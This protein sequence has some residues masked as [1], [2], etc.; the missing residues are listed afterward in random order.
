MQQKLLMKCTKNILLYIFDVIRVLSDNVYST[1]IFLPGTIY[2]QVLIHFQVFKPIKV[3]ANA[4]TVVGI[5]Y[6]CPW[7]WCVYPHQLLLIK[8]NGG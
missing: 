7:S 6:N 1:E 3:Y 4:S 5:R 8:V 2:N